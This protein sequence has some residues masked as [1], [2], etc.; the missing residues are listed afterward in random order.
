MFLR[1]GKKCFACR[2][3]SDYF[4]I[5]VNGQT[6]D[7]VIAK[8]RSWSKVFVEHQSKVYPG[9]D[10][11]L[12]N[13]VYFL[14]RGEH[15]IALAMDNANLARKQAKADQNSLYCICTD[16]LRAK[17]SYEQTI[18]GEIQTAIRD[19]KIEV[20]LLPKF[21]LEGRKVIG[22]EAL[23][24]WVNDDGTYRSP[25]DFIPILE[26]TGHITD[27]DFCI[28]TNVLQTL[29]N[30]KKKGIPMVPISVNFSKHN[31]SFAKF[32]ERISRLAE[33]YG[34]DAVFSSGGAAVS[35]ETGE[36]TMTLG[37]VGYSAG[38]GVAY[39]N[40]ASAASG[41]ATVSVD[42]CKLRLNYGEA[43]LDLFSTASF[44]R[45]DARIAAL[46]AAENITLAD[47][48]AIASV[49]EACAALDPDLCERFVTRLDELEAAEAA[50]AALVAAIP[51]ELTVS[52]SL[53]KK[54][55]IGSV[56][57]LPAATAQDNPDGE[58][59]VTVEVIDPDGIDVFSGGTAA[60]DKYGVYTVTYSAVDSD[61]NVTS[62]SYM[63]TVREYTRC[64][65]N[66]DGSVTAADALKA[67][68]IA[69]G[70]V[71]ADTLDIATGD[72]DGDGEITVADALR[73]L[74]KAVGLDA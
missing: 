50:L 36:E 53:P 8:L 58:L 19:N 68:R 69:A 48:A 74:R 12:T 43:S 10:I 21:S 13:G 32:D 14:R 61:G 52:G 39:V 60:L 15:D 37:G 71:T 20:F 5:Y 67:L 24:R 56:I 34:V 62:V 64:D 18:A 31:S 6:E 4:L 63:I 23:A 41:M 65:M 25:A 11:Q 28:Y 51:P 2:I 40:L 17:R 29:R 45:V 22:A 72:M 16:E 26:K 30:W 42:G 47:A 3:H 27:L 49:R 55:L 57:T 9:I 59:A 1:K 54:A 44:E 7:Q 70:L 35:C 46:P 73:I 66:N 38:A 33:Q